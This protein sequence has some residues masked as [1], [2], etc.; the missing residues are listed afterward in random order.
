[1]I[2]L[3]LFSDVTSPKFHSKNKEVI[4]RYD[5][6]NRN[7]EEFKQVTGLEIGTARFYVL[8][9]KPILIKSLR[10]EKSIL[11]GTGS[12]TS[13]FQCL[14]EDLKTSRCSGC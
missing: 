7:P 8:V 5:S 3:L 2:N 14:S 12:L 6:E 13:T 4:G 10:K 9:S 1:M 11:G